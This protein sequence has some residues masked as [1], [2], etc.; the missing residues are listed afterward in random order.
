MRTLPIAR[1]EAR[2][3]PGLLALTAR[4]VPDR[5][6]LRFL[7]PGTG[8][9]P[10][11]VSFSAFRAGVCRAAAFLERAGVKRG[12][13]VLL[14]AENSPEWQAVALGAQL[15]GA[16]PSA[17]FASL[18]PPAVQDIAPRVRP[19]VAFVSTKEQWAK[20]APV[21]AALAAQGLTSVLAVDEEVS[22]AAPAGVQGNTVRAAI[23]EEAPGIALDGVRGPRRVRPRG[24]PVPPALHQRHHRAAE[25][26]A[27]GAADHRPRH[28]GRALSA[29]RNEHDVGL[30][31]L[32]FGHVAGHDQFALALAQGHTLLLIA[33]PSDAPR[34]FALGPD[35]R[36]LG[37]AG[38][39]AHPDTGAGGL[40]HL[41]AP[42]KR[43]VDHALEAAA[44]VR[45][46]G[47]SGGLDVLRTGVA[48]L[49]VGRKVR[50]ALGG[51]IVGLFA[52]GAPTSVALFRFFEGLGIPLV[53]LY[54]M[55][56]TAGMISSNLFGERRRPSI[57]GL[58]CPDHELRIAED[59]ELLL[60]GPLMLS[61][62]LEPEDDTDAFTA[63]GFF[64]TGDLGELDADGWLHITGRKKHLLVLSTGK[65]VAPE[66]LE[67]ALGSTPP[68]EGALLLGDGRPFVTAAVFVPR[69]ELTRLKEEGRI[70]RKRS[71]PWHWSPWAPSPTTRS[72]GSCSSSRAARP[73]TRSSSPRR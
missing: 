40:G 14:L 22:R 39:R 16:E 29:G 24:G 55:S 19:R 8:G 9:P 53:E 66:P 49:L 52:G 32:P 46:D 71:S 2:T 18:G 1:F 30:H 58:V 59:H 28:R 50:K 7:A 38:I 37:S 43:F 20:L 51:H 63:D 57:A 73:T 47:A 44:R 27:P 42:V 65:K 11:D 25:G 70:R 61:G 3:L 6:F 21:A 26:G 72:R 62:Y 68:F 5:L 15:L 23:G 60:R 41:P 35:L 17:L 10:R 69:G 33:H 54:G 34:A 12:D 64:R 31:L 48:D 13:R 36:L 45:V 4:R 56:E 67:T